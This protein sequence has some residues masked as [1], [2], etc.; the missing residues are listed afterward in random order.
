MAAVAA[1]AALA[2]LASH[3]LAG[4]RL[5]EIASRAGADRRMLYAHFGSKE[6]LWLVVLG[7]AY[8]AKR[9]EERALGAEA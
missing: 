8:A 3:G 6:E 2:E 1:E 7:Q 5:D 4:A 9:A